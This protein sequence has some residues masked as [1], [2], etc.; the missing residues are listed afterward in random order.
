MP[1]LDGIF[2]LPPRAEKRFLAFCPNFSDTDDPDR[3]PEQG[4][5]PSLSE[6][7]MITIPEPDSFPPRGVRQVIQQCG[8]VPPSGKR[9]SL[10]ATT[11]PDSN[12][13]RG[14]KGISMECAG[15]SMS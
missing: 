1:S 11:P 14:P 4:L 13:N 15:I 6:C 12:R 9:H 3:C 10:G 7:D 5:S 8:R 2:M